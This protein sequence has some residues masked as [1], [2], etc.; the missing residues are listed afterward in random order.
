MRK[1]RG[2]DN[3]ISLQ[4]ENKTAAVS[5]FFSLIYSLTELR[6]VYPN[7]FERKGQYSLLHICQLP[8]DLRVHL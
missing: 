2:R 8:P 4:T 7:Y 6:Q 5:Q 3:D 1:N